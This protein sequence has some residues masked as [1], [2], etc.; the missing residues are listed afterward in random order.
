MT[1]HGTAAAHE[2]VQEMLAGYAAGTVG[3]PERELVAAH[4]ETCGEC[5]GELATWQAVRTSVRSA[6]PAASA[7][8]PELVTAVL[9]RAQQGDAEP[10]TSRRLDPLAAFQQAGALLA[11]QVPVVRAR[12]W[13]ASALVMALGGA[14]AA[15]DTRGTAGLVLAFVAPVVAAVGL[16]VVHGPRVDPNLE[17]ALSSPTS[18]RTVLL[19][20]LTLVFGYDLALGLAASAALS[21]TGSTGGLW[22]V[23]GAW[24]GPMALLSAVSLAVSMWR[25]PNVAMGAAMVL[26]AARVVT[27]LPSGGLPPAVQRVAEVL[28]STNAA[29]VGLALLIVVV[30]LL[31]LP[32]RMQPRAAG[33]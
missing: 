19:A 20:R 5:R 15:A 1:T 4:L 12:L 9:Q 32:R 26:W 28:W 10:D 16:A 14:L 30:A 2:R 21:A 8:G 6:A 22:A 17:V 29:T 23:V 18:P 13:L 31:W 25:G 3:E 27:L 33:E 24:L 11:G 7:P